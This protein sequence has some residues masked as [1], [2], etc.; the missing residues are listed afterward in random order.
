MPH[1]IYGKPSHQLDSATFTLV[2]P[3]RRNGYL[4]SLDVAGNSDTQR[5]RL[6]SVKETWTVAE[7]EC[8][9]QPTDALHHLALIVA[10]DRPASQ[11]AVF[12][13]LTGEPWVQESLPGF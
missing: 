11:E 12:R 9:L 1:P 3:S 5:P 13:Q 4:T 2:L 7:Q 6:W 8:G 10:Q